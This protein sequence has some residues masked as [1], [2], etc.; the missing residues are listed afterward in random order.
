ML[1]QPLIYQKKQRWETSFGNWFPS[2]CLGRIK[3]LR[4][5]SALH[6]LQRPLFTKKT[7]QLR[8]YSVVRLLHRSLICKKKNDCH[9]IMFCYF[10]SDP[11]LVD[12]DGQARPGLV[13]VPPGLINNW[14]RELTRWAS[15]L[16]VHIY[17]GQQCKLPEHM[18]DI[19]VLLRSYHAVRQDADKT[20]L[21]S[22]LL[23]FFCKFFLSYANAS[24]DHVC[25]SS[26]ILLV[27]CF[28]VSTT[29]PGSRG[30]APQK[31]I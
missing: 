30:C 16:R 8:F 22:Q 14:R 12:A 17:H 2:D 20:L 27:Y 15:S 19:D 21:G 5:Y 9:S 7:N 28:N 29:I 4:F 6:V 25:N 10:Y 31:K 13:V 11:L 1:L 18:G 24:G 3:P 23:P 26:K